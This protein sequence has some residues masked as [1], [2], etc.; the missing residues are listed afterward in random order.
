MAY[1]WLPNRALEAITLLVL[2]LLSTT[3][4]LAPGQPAW[5][6]GL[7]I[8]AVAIPGWVIVGLVHVKAVRVVPKNFRGTLT[9][10]IVAGE[11]ALVPFAVTG[12][13]LLLHA[14]GGLY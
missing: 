12:V 10:R 8:L 6:L 2:V 5:A 11:A 9:F 13:T 7:E 4:V 1:P 3:L 14:G